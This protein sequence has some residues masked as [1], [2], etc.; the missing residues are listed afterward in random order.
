M[1]FGSCSQVVLLNAIPRSQ[2]SRT[3]NDG[4]ELS[5]SELEL[6]EKAG[7]GNGVSVIQA[8]SIGVVGQRSNKGYQL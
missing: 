8:S 7:G 3:T 4:Y 2:S 5:T 6:L 1:V